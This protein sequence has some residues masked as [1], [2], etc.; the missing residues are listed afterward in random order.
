MPPSFLSCTCRM[1]EVCELKDLKEVPYDHND[2]MVYPELSAADSGQARLHA[3]GYRQELRRVFTPVTSF[4]TS[5]VL[6]ADT[7]PITGEENTTALGACNH[8]SGVP[9]NVSSGACIMCGAPCAGF[10]STAYMNG[11][12][13]SVVWGWCVHTSALRIHA[14]RMDRERDL[15]PMRAGG[16][17][18]S[19]MRWW[20]CPWRR[21]CRPTR[22]LEGP[23]SGEASTPHAQRKCVFWELPE[24]RRSSWAATQCCPAG[25]GTSAF[26][27]L[28]Q[29]AGAY[30]ERPGLDT[31]GMDNRYADLGSV[32][33]QTHAPCTGV[34]ALPPNH[35]AAQ[36]SA[37]GWCCA[38]AGSTSWANLPPPRGAGAQLSNHVANMWLLANG[39]V[40]TPVEVLLTFSSAKSCPGAPTLGFR[41]FSVCPNTPIPHVNQPLT[42]TGLP[43]QWQRA[44]FQEHPAAQAHACLGTAMT[45]AVP[46]ARSFPGDGWLPQQHDVGGSA[47]L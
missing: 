4:S 39:H 23:T 10:L 29:G 9:G 36:P 21:L 34:S 8:S 41:G 11:G 20:L 46:A 24:G 43:L 30:K 22:L 13:V 33:E 44:V 12:P 2:N 18:L 35:A 26:A 45:L 31:S 28:V 38:Q 37:E 16:S 17:A 42:W 47:D 40:F 25:W 19:Q 14:L 27:D 7:A 15:N 1:A 32:P 6:M 5:L 3:L